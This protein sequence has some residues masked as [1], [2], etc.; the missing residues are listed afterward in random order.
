MP[1]KNNHYGY[2]IKFDN[3]C[4]L[5]VDLL[6][7]SLFKVTT[8]KKD[9]PRT[10]SV[11]TTKMKLLCYLLEKANNIIVSREELLS[12]VWEASSLSSS[13]PRL[14]QVVKKLE[15]DLQYLGVPDDFI[16]Y[17]RGEG[18]SITCKYILK[19]YFK[20]EGDCSVVS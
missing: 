7:K 2:L 20:T 1:D 6:H 9:E 5:Q 10:L 12:N 18:Y 19:L 17:S 4:C 16:N 11:R 13:Y 14:L 8:T 15:E 3:G